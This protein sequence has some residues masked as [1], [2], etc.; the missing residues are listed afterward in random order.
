MSNKTGDLMTS[1][2]QDGENVILRQSGALASGERQHVYAA[3][4]R[5]EIS[6]QFY[7]DG[8]EWLDTKPILLSLGCSSHS[9]RG[10]AI[11]PK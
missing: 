8:F 1:A 10:A 3:D 5:R 7:P 6:L 2:S 9:V 11:S 4:M